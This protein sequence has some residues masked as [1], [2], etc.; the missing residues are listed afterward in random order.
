MP[1]PIGPTQKR[2]RDRPVT[3]RDPLASVRLPRE[4]LDAIEAIVAGE[5]A[6]RSEVLRRAVVEWLA[7]RDA[8]EEAGER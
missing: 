5:G 2:K 1:A 6:A 4:A 8:Q 3:G 7:R